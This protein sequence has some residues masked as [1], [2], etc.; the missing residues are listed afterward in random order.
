MH[1]L[2]VSTAATIQIGPL[3]DPTDLHAV[4]CLA[5]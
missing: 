4:H 2:K 3:L 1:Y 5:G